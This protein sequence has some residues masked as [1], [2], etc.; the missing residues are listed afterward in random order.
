MTTILTAFNNLLIQ[1]ID[2][3]IILF[4]ADTEFKMTKNALS[5]LKSANPR[6]LAT[7]V[8]LHLNMYSEKIAEKDETFFLQNDYSEL[9][10]LSEVKDSNKFSSIIDKLK[11]YW[12][13]L[14]DENKAAIWK[15]LD[16][17]LALSKKIN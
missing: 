5:L 7:L 15:Y 13:E 17:L 8:S 2:E 14:S 11:K 10:D 3:L 16:T 1:F 12:L 9:N 4:P 6:K